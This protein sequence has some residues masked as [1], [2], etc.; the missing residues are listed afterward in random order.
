LPRIPVAP[1]TLVMPRKSAK[2]VQLD[3]EDMKA[4]KRAEADG[5][6]PSELVRRSLR[7]AAARY[8]RGVRRP[9]NVNLLVSTDPLLGEESE[10]Y[11]DFRE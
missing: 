8:Y 10:L 2:T 7:V 6:S 4:L 5:V 9:P 1:H 3:P 11:R